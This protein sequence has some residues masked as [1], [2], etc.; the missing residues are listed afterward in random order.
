MMTLESSISLKLHLLTALELSFTIITCLQYK[1][2]ESTLQLICTAC[3]HSYK[4]K[5]IILTTVVNITLLFFFFTDTASNFHKVFVL[6][7][8]L[9]SSLMFLSKG[10]GHQSGRFNFTPQP[11]IYLTRLKKLARVW[12]KP[13]SKDFAVKATGGQTLQLTCPEHQ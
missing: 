10:G 7:K 11:R 4:E 3:S 1:P 2:Q 5:I 6:G 8:H 12:P 9:Q 13:Y